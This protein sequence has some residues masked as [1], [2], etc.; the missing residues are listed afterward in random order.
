M[1]YSLLPVQIAE[2]TVVSPLGR[3]DHCVAIVS[4]DLPRKESAEVPFHRTVYRYS[5]A[6]WDGFRDDYFLLE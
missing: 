5:K 2:L 3:S 1:T 6:D 4:L